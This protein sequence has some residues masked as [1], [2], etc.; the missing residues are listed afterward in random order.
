MK[1]IRVYQFG[2]TSELLLEDTPRPEAGFGEVLI[3][4]SAAGVGPWD[5]WVRS[6]KSALPQPLPLTPG[7]DLSGV[8]VAIGAGVTGFKIGQEVFGV[9][10]SN[11]TGAYAE[12]AVA[13]AKMIALRPSRLSDIDAACVPV[14]AVTA[15]QALVGEAK[16][17][18][19]QTVLI[20]GAAGNVGAYAVQLAR[21]MGLRVFVTTGTKDIN[22][23]KSLG[24]DRVIDYLSEKFEDVT[25][26]VDAV[27]DLVGGDTQTR[28]FA[29][30]KAG[31]R[32]IS[33]VSQPDQ[34][35][36]AALGIDAHFFL[37][38][39]TTERLT[40]I[41]NIIETGELVIQVGTVLPLAAARSAHEM[42]EGTRP[43]PR[44]K[45]VLRIGA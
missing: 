44:G 23:V 31:G 17:T 9:T 41:A 7:S 35:K 3:K 20:H 21:R 34:D 38:D 43:H 25:G 2:G 37:V 45:I 42:L 4:V 40:T 36:A 15:W 10:N 19:G 5:A 28:S 13:S 12:Y 26:T 30:L 1:A 27:I 29:V 33:A 24:A 11:F 14:V 18:R 39:V 22:F 16:L 32:L 8:I 6:G